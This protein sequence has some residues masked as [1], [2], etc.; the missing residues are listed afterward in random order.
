LHSWLAA[1]GVASAEQWTPTATGLT[2]GRALP[3]GISL[4][5]KAVTSYSDSCSGAWLAL[6][7][8]GTPTWAGELAFGPATVSYSWN[9][10]GTL[11]SSVP[12]NDVGQGS[13]PLDETNI[14]ITGSG[15]WDENAPECE[16][17]ANDGVVSTGGSVPGVLNASLT[18]IYNGSGEVTDFK[19]LTTLNS[20]GSFSGPGAAE[21]EN[22][23]WQQT[24]NPDLNNDPCTSGTNATPNEPDS[25]ASQEVYD[26]AQ[27][28][29]N[30]TEAEQIQTT[31]W[32]INHS[33][34]EETGGVWASKTISQTIPYNAVDPTQITDT[35][36]ITVAETYQIVTS[37]CGPKSSGVSPAAPAAAGALTV[38]I[39][40]TPT[41][42]RFPEAANAAS[43]TYFS[44]PPR[45]H[46][47]VNQR[48][49]DVP[50]NATQGQYDVT[51]K[52]LVTKVTVDLDNAASGSAL[53]RD[54]VADG[55][56]DKVKMIGCGLLEVQVT[57]SGGVTSEINTVPP[58]AEHIAYKFTIEVRDPKT[59]ATATSEP[60]SSNPMHGLWRMPPELLSR[61]FGCREDGTAAGCPARHPDLGGDD[62]VSYSTYFWMQRHANLLTAIND[63]SGEHGY[64]LGHQSHGTGDDIDEFHP[65]AKDGGV[66]QSG[67]TYYNTLAIAV[68][69]ALQSNPKD[70]NKDIAA[71]EHVRAW[72]EAT[73]RAIHELLAL[74]GRDRVV[75][76]LYMAGGEIVDPKTHEA[77][78]G[79]GWAENLLMSG[80]CSGPGGNLKY[81]KLGT[82]DQTGPLQFN[83][84]HNNHL[85]IRLQT[86][87]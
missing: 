21:L 55:L 45:G 3:P 51:D 82:W 9:G 47:N 6:P 80:T 63:I 31:G 19:L 24:A 10:R 11:T 53:Q 50:F 33:W 60:I 37:P 79:S 46:A 83:Q 35:G 70:P 40:G 57:F 75:L 73:R 15:K 18:P 30:Y 43:L 41:P 26:V 1:D 64:D 76:I 77:V 22:Y 59:G 62:W 12:I 29:S 54:I 27:V 14:S 25:N 67:T 16:I 74:S 36:S 68:R 20:T 5:F 34:T 39:S 85:H 42:V 2:S 38:T 66:G 28:D 52:V 44:I 49:F 78:L 65:A 86:I 81:M 58:P 48:Y 56:G 69:D 84:V 4:T 61:R 17:V 72:V 23:S 7:G 87:P 71:Q 13:A 8:C 32:T